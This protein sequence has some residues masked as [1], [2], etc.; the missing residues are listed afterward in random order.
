M[1]CLEDSVD[2]PV[3]FLGAMRAGAIP[4][5][6]NTLLTAKDYAYIVADSEAKLLVVS[7]ALLP[8]WR[9][10]FD[11]TRAPRHARLW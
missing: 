9:T 7:A 6:L 4:V 5:P 8:A 2:F 1:L 11:S 10:V 3:C